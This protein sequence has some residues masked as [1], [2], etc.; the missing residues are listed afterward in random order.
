MS[1]YVIG[2]DYGTLSARALLIELQSGAEIAEAE[3]TY[4]HAILQDSDFAGVRLSRDA[5]LQHPRD[6][7]DAL[8]ATFS[9]VLHRSGVDPADIIGVGVD[10][11]AATVLPVTEDGTPL[12]F[13]PQFQNEP[14]AY[15]KLWK[16]HGAQWEADRMTHVAQDR[17]E[18][19]LSQYG[20]KVSSEWML[21]KVYETLRKAPQVYHSAARYI[22][23]GDWLVWK[24]TGKECRS[25]CMAGFKVLWSKETGYPS[26]E[27]LEAVDPGLAD[28]IGTKIPVEV[29]PTGTKAGS[30]SP[31]GAGLTGLCVGTAVTVPIV[32]GHAGIPGAGMVDPGQMM[33]ILGTSSA[34]FVLDE[35]RRDIPGI[36]GCVADGVIPGFY[37]Y[38]AGQSCVGDGFGW[39]IENCVPEKYAREARTRNTDI[40]TLLNEKAA[41]LEIGKSGIV[42]LDWWNGN[43]SP[44]ADYD[45]SGLILGLTLKTRPEEI[46]RAFIEAT[47]FGTKAIVD[48]YL[49]GGIQIHEIR[50]AGGISRKN[51]FLMQLYADVLGMP[52]RVCT[53]TQ[54]TAKGIAVFA[55]VA[56][57]YYDNVRDAAA[58]ISDKCSVCYTPNP[59]NTAK[60][61][62]LYREYQELSQYFG[63]ETTMMKR[64]KKHCATK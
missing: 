22:E 16:H 63:K 61:W 31:E 33:L 6:Y 8:R 23:A 7:L 49:E 28:L 43:R 60:Y 41:E 38:E 64:L 50:A 20:G 55:A 59:N 9:Q 45:L 37:A 42:A 32:D 62:P 25:S 44:L 54:A 35:E 57:G 14:H 17:G 51:P 12:R 13:L 11:T 29:S 53:S 2:I 1:K 40:F 21:P 48:R 46:Y 52:I 56:S 19:W 26:R 3:Y 27:Y 30:I 10:F 58:V 18:A 5:A 34:H 15:A 24:L 36:C 47:A 39:F 4:P